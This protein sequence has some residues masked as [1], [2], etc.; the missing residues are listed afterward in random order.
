MMLAAAALIAKADDSSV[1]QLALQNTGL[2]PDA[3][4]SLLSVLKSKSSTVKISASRLAPGQDYVLTVGD[5]AEAT[6]VADKR[7]RVSVTFSTKP[8]RSKALLGFDPRGQQVALRDGTNIVLQAVVSGPAEPAGSVVDERAK[9]T[10]LS[11]PGE[12]EVRYQALRNGR[13]F[14]VV[15]IERAEA[16]E[17]SLFVNGLA[18]GSIQVSG[19]QTTLFFDSAPSRPSRRVL[20]FDPRGQVVD[21]ALGTNLVFTGTLEA[22]AGN[23]NV[24]S[25]ALTQAFIPSTSVDPDGIAKATYRV[26]PDARRKF[27]VEL[28]NVAAGQYELLANGVR[29]GVIDVSA[30]ADGTEGEIEFSSRDEHGDERPLLFDPITTTL[31]VRSGA[32]VYFQGQLAGAGDGTS[33]PPAGSGL[34]PDT[35]AGLTFNLDDQPGGDLLRFDTATTGVDLGTR[36]DPFSY[37]L[38]R[39]NASQV[40]MELAEGDKLDVYVFTFSADTAGSWVRDEYRR[41]QFTDRDT[42]RFT[43]VAGMPD[44]SG[45]TNASGTNMPVVFTSKIEVPLFN[46]GIASGATAGAKF[47]SDDRGRRSFEVEIEDAPAGSYALWVADAQVGTFTVAATLHGT[48]G[49]I[50]FEEDDGAHL[51]LTFDP[52]GKAITVSRDGVNYFHRVFPATD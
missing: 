17:W 1:I 22:K 21:L 47:S 14:F 23:V 36:P 5:S 15:K 50:Q 8:G 45:S 6:V 9:L 30:S 20:D 7:G 29:Q 52:L 34:A 38:A 27:S 42:G 13:R 39:M 37:V 40:R 11:G 33:V 18:R 43:I 31:I 28:E 32:V 48:Q 51:P 46:L 19:R 41:G 26:D 4:G 35:F 44:H 24:A 3:A 25:P 49:G 10:P 12:A 2:V 16:G